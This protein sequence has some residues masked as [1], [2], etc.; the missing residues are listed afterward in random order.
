MSIS[1]LSKTDFKEFV[2][3]LLSSGKM[4]MGVQAHG[5]RFAF[6][7][8]KSAG[9][10]RLD[11]DVTILPP[12]KYVLPQVETL[13]TYTLPEQYKSQ[14]QEGE[15][16]LLGVHP[17][18]MAAINQMDILFSQDQYD[19]HYMLRRKKMTIIACDVATPSKNVFAASMGTATVHEGY[20]ILLTD[21]GDAYVIEAATDKGRSLVQGAA[22]LAN[23]SAQDEA[24]R[25]AVWDK[26]KI[27]LNKHPLKCKPSDIPALLDKAYNHP[28]WDEKARTCFA[29][30]SCNTTCPT[31]YCFDVQDDVSWDRTAGKRYRAWDGCLLENFATVAG[32]H[33][34]RKARADRFRHRLY[35]K[36]KYVP[37][38]IGGR[39]ACVG[40][41]RC[42][43]ACIP[44]IANPVAIYNRLVE[45]LGVAPKK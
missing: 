22:G 17:Y 1:K 13:L 26:N 45:D 5:E 14:Y 41:G 39:I 25:Q 33:N 11:Y 34:F 40:C 21:I 31:C 23:A 6:D 3:G 2:D 35:R 4:V 9:D 37:A 12:K 15:M 38:K 29:C 43:T 20:D 16:I 44:D 32:N 28:V 30:G 24:A 8:L 7:V 18:D 42:I 27:E 36:G 10:L 19:T